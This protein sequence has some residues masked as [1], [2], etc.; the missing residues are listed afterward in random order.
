[1]EEE[2]PNKPAQKMIG[3]RESLHVA[4]NASSYPA[5]IPRV[6]LAQGA[7]LT[8][9][10]VNGEREKTGTSKLQ[11]YI[12]SDSRR[13]PRVKK[14]SRVHSADILMGDASVDNCLRKVGRALA[15]EDVAEVSETIISGRRGG[16]NQ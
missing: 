7:A 13:R 15:S 14:V 3:N 9:P 10:S 16:H 12:S 2:K 8:R 6:I 4:G 1:M 11:F 5:N